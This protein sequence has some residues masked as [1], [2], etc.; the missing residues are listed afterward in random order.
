MS[1][2]TAGQST[3]KLGDK[4]IDCP[5]ILDKHNAIYKVIWLNRRCKD[6]FLIHSNKQPSR[7]KIARKTQYIQ[8]KFGMTIE[9]YNTK[10]EIQLNGCAICKQPCKTG[11]ALS[12]DHN[13]NTKVNRDLLCYRCNVLVGYIEQD[14]NLIYETIE[15]LKRHQQ[16]IA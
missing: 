15:Y 5:N 8:W 2:R 11:K 4:C 12:I 13:H 10:L 9:E 14:E 6:C 1:G 16:K 3:P 7:T